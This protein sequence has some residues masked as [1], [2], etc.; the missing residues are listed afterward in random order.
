MEFFLALLLFFM[1]LFICI[2]IGEAAESITHNLV[3]P[4]EKRAELYIYIEENYSGY[5]MCREPNPRSVH[6]KK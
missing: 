5:E 6:S 3:C 1:I 2:S 4:D